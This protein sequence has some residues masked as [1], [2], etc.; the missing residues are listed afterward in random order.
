MPVAAMSDTEPEPDPAWA[1]RFV[2]AANSRH[3]VVLWIKSGDEKC[4]SVR[5]IFQSLH[6]KTLVVVA[7]AVPKGNL[8][9][10]Y[11]EI[12]TG[13][14]TLPAIWIGGKFIGGYEELKELMHKKELHP[15]LLEALT[16]NWRQQSIIK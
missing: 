14:R 1:L 15:K 8:M 5:S 12:E 13:H 6:V 4:E 9:R 2:T 10:G 3:A 11:I 16:M 7:D